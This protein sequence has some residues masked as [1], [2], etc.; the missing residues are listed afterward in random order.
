[1]KLKEGLQRF[2]ESYSVSGDYAQKI[3]VTQELQEKYHIEEKLGKLR[4]SGRLTE[5]AANSGVLYRFPIS[6]FD[7]LN[8]NRRKYPRALWENV[9]REQQHE[10]KGRV[11]LADHPPEE[12][13]GEFKNAA[14]IWHDM[15]ID[16]DNNLIWG[17]ATFV[18]PFGRLA[19][20]I[21][22]N[23]GRVGFSS[24]GFGELMMDGSTVNPD[25][26][27]LERCADVVLNPSQDV[28]GDSTNA[29][30]IEYTRSEPKGGNR[31]VGFGENTVKGTNLEEN[32][33]GE[34]AEA[35]LS[36]KENRMANNEARPVSKLEEKK[37][38]RDIQ[39]FLEDASRMEN[40]QARL[41]EL[42]EI[43]T[44]FEEGVAQDLREEVEA[45]ILEEK[46]N[47][48][49]LLAEAAKTQEAFGTS[50]SEKLKLGVA[51]LAEEVKVAEAEAKDWEKIAVVL[52]ENNSKLRDALKEAHGKLNTMPSIEYVGE[53]QERIS[54]LETQRKRSVNAYTEETKVKDTQLTEADQL[55]ESQNKLIV[56]LKKQLEETKVLVETTKFSAK[57]QMKKVAE[58]GDALAAAKEESEAKEETIQAQEA[59]I[60][61]LEGT[62]ERLQNSLKEANDKNADL[63]NEFIA[64]Q[65]S[66][67]EINTMK[68]MPTAAERMGSHLNFRENGG[69]AVES[70]WADLVSRH[71]ESIKPFERKI[72]GAKTYKEASSEYIKALSSLDENHQDVVNARLPESTSISLKE[73]K[74]ML[75]EAGMKF[76]NEKTVVD[77]MP[78]GWN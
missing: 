18:G 68:V 25:T 72:R 76:G 41:T 61:T 37:F 11:G 54:V 33:N 74:A 71:G 62:V 1:M 60:K 66:Y 24:S 46:K 26:F 27:Q 10:W 39:T 23:G 20:E 65:E 9:L 3:P 35:N 14:I 43:M 64:F 67:E 48:E 44:Y 49:N 29:L 50:D 45:K 21:V 8:H 22:D 75:E 47:L 52:K 5:G 73:R 56:D 34:S 6:R 42:E 36:I 69:A 59:T 38:R 40:P 28:F 16:D 55:I 57:E 30:N 13:D 31:S 70:Y 51:L 32:K 63:E 17:T 15:E 7:H 19:Q 12:S 53:L 4:E 58:N 2:T 77:R 78:K